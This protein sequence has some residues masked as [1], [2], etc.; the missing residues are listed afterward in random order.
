M[1]I[2]FCLGAFT[3]SGLGLCLGIWY[4]LTFFPSPPQPVT[5][6]CMNEGFQFIAECVF[7]L[8]SVSCGSAA[9]CCLGAITSMFIKSK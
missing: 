2:K 4:G 1:K 8:T 3:G 9:G 7:M 5:S 6:Y